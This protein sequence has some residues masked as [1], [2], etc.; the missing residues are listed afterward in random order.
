MHVHQVPLKSMHKG[1]ALVFLPLPLLA[2][3]HHKRPLG[4]LAGDIGQECTG[5]ERT[6]EDGCPGESSNGDERAEDQRH[7]DDVGDVVVPRKVVLDEA[8]EDGRKEPLGDNGG[9]NGHAYRCDNRAP[10][11]PAQVDIAAALQLSQVANDTTHQYVWI[12]NTGNLP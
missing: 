7:Q 3:H 12:W 6:K 8:A 11:E 5:Q 9:H 1:R 4:V 2:V 10:N